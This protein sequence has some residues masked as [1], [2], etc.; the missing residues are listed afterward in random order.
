M[1]DIKPLFLIKPKSMSR[2]DIKRAEAG[3]FIIVECSEP[4]AARFLEPPLMANLDE[5]ARA[6]LWLMRFVTENQGPYQRADLT[7]NL[8]KILMDGHRP[9]AVPSVK[10]K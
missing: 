8:V 5:Q 9:A 7:R 10:A 6:G 1:A 4:E 2:R 3:G